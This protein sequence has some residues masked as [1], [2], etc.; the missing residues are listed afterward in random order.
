MRFHGAALQRPSIARELVFQSDQPERS[1]QAKTL[2]QVAA[3]QIR[4]PEAGDFLQIFWTEIDLRSVPFYLQPTRHLRC[5]T[6]RGEIAI[7]EDAAAGKERASC[8]D[9]KPAQRGAE[10]VP[11]VIRS[12]AR[13]WIRTNHV[14]GQLAVALAF[15][16][17]FLE[18]RAR[19]QAPL[20]CFLTSSVF[21]FPRASPPI[22]A[23]E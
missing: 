6:K 3:G 1:A 20:T 16:G 11:F 10:S 14:D 18:T 5:R 22:K 13:T 23:T 17:T 21:R 2:I 7:K 8:G 12:K 4:I 19:R 15:G 9:A